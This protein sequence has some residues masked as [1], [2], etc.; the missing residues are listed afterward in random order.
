M[1]N[2]TTPTPA[3]KF[4]ADQVV[5]LQIENMQLE[6]EILRLKGNISDLKISILR[7]AILFDEVLET[8][9]NEK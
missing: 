3:Q 1:E 8:L 9:D 5:D 7:A 4:L 6:T 2:L